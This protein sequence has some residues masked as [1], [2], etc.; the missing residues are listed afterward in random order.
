MV[1]RSVFV[2][3]TLAGAA[4][5]LLFLPAGQ[6][7]S[8]T[9]REVFVT[10]FPAVQRVA[11]EV[12]VRGPVKLAASV[13]IEEITVPPIERDETTRFV[14]A[15]VIDTEGFPAVVLS[16]HGVVKGHVGRTGTIGAI[17]LPDEPSIR[18]AFDEQSVMHF[19][20]ETSAGGV[21]AK[22]P[23]FASE[24]HR[25]GLAFPRY[26]VFLYNTTDKTVSVNLFAYLTG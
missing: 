25:Y 14:D 19:Y 8:Q 12:G 16:L 3:L 6:A 5:G 18:E 9:V 1:R 4:L 11:G 13:K 23:Y 7:V 10:N 21:N 2:V 17:L 26:R 15:G 20:L 22:T 24:Q